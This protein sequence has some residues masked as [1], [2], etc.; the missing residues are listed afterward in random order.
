MTRVASTAMSAVSVL[1]GA[2]PQWGGV[3]D[4]PHYCL[5][6]DRKVAVKH[7]SQGNADV[8]SPEC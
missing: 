7:H 4:F 8:F 6:C 3:R 5:R 2:G 1:V